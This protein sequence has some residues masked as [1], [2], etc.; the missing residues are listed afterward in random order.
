MEERRAR[1]NRGFPLLNKEE[2]R[3]LPSFL[4]AARCFILREGTADAF[5]NLT[6][7]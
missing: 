4:P 2:V 7:N 3:F 1:L 5:F 6:L